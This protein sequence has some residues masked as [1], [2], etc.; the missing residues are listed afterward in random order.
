VNQYIYI[1]DVPFSAAVKVLPELNRAGA[2][3]LWPGEDELEGEEESLQ[4]RMWRHERKVEHGYVEWLED[5]H[6][7][8]HEHSNAVAEEPRTVGYVTADVGCFILFFSH[9]A[10]TRTDSPAPASATT[11]RTRLSQRTVFRT[12]SPR[13]HL[14]LAGPTRSSTSSSSTSSRRR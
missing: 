12:L 10:D 11:R 3:R 5:M 7:R 9:S 14:S 13:A 8:Y 2:E 4:M 1:P 6:R